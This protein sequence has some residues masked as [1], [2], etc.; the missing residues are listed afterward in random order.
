MGNVNIISKIKTLQLSVSYG[1]PDAQQSS[2]LDP[3]WNLQV[4]EVL[5]AT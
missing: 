2:T 5:A 4:M 1:K 3:E